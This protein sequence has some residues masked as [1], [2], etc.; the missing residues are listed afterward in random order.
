M[1]ENSVPVL[2][3]VLVLLLLLSAFFSSAET[4][5]L[6]LNRF[7]LRAMAREG[8]R[9]ARLTSHLLEQTDKLLST[10][11]LFNNLV[12]SAAA[13]VVSEIAHI[14]LGP[15]ESTLALATGIATFFILVFSEITPKIIAVSYPERIAYPASYTLAILLKL[16]Q[17]VVWVINLFVDGLLRAL[18]LTKRPEAATGV[19]LEELRS[20]IYDS[21]L[22]PKRHHRLLVNLLELDRI[23][24]DDVMTP[25]S[26]IE[27]I[28]LEAAPETVRGQLATSHHTRL[29]VYRERLD[30][31]QGILHVRKAL[32][33]VSADEFDLA[34]LGEV[35]REPYFVPSGTTLFAQLQ[36]FQENHRRIGLVVDEYGELMGLVSLEDIL[37]EIVGE[38]TTQ[39]PGHQGSGRRDSEGHW[40]V[41]GSSLLRDLNR[42]L[43]THFP[44]DGPKTLNGLILEHFE[45]IPEHG[46]C[47]D[48]RGHYLEIVQ[49]HEKSVKTVRIYTSSPAL[50]FTSRAQ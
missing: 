50:S 23:T 48:L 4:S 17:P 10:I 34:A 39:A 7:R 38:F 28:D 13:V 5:L 21:P 35:M 20:I 11:L 6:T 37:E 46:T 24:V 47:L 33:L 2:V 32:H 31:I 43:G 9:A 22:L 19:N 30:E 29:P 45:E 27:A 49:T 12:N 36:Q 8:R 25:R 16:A 40:L 26:Q 3:G 41:E 18:R 42:K 44:V 14:Y 15:S 1:S